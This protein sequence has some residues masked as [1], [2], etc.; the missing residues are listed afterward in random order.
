MSKGSASR[1]FQQCKLCAC[2][3]VS[4][5]L[6]SHSQRVVCVP[7]FTR[8]LKNEFQ[9]EPSRTSMDMRVDLS[10]FVARCRCK[11][12]LRAVLQTT[13]RITAQSCTGTTL[14]MRHRSL[15]K[16][17]RTWSSQPCCNL[18]LCLLLTCNLAFEFR[19]LCICVYVYMCICLLIYRVQSPSCIERCMFA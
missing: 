7:L 8:F 12:E 3:P 1:A 2:M 9:T 4:E 15:S 16:D 6:E 13:V 17:S 18:S 14:I 19:V 5:I 11:A 10:F